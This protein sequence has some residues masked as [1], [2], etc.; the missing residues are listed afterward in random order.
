MRVCGDL[1]SGVQRELLHHVSD[2][3]LNGMRRDVETRGNL[4]VTQAFADQIYDL[5]LSSGHANRLHGIGSPPFDCLARDLREECRSQLGRKDLRAARHRT[6]RADEF[7]AGG[8]LQYEA[9]DPCVHEFDD[10]FVN[11]QKI[12]NDDF[13]LR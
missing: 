10:V 12:H 13:R 11:R 5:P 6:D 3:T 1:K 2:V 9:T 8:V 7:L 4:L